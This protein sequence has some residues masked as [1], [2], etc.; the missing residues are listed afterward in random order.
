MKFRYSKLALAEPDEFFGNYL[1]KPIIPVR[2]SHQGQQIDYAALIDSGA[3]FNIFDAQIGELLGLNIEDGT[4]VEFVG[5]Q[6]APASHTWIHQVKITIDGWEHETAI[7]FSYD[8][9]KYGYGLLGQQG[10]FN[11]FVVKFD[12]L[13]EEIELKPRK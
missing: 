5:V 7:G 11:L 12:L 6:Q 3:D 13:K 8:I 9:A 4:P 1:L 2:L 10:F